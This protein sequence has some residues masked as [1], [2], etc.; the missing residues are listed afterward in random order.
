[1]AKLL[2]PQDRLLLA[3]A[4]IGDLLEELPTKRDYLNVIYG[5]YPKEYNRNNYLQAF[6]RARETG[7][8][9]KI[10]K[11]GEPYLRLTAKGKKRV[12]RDFPLLKWRERPW[13]GKWRAVIFDIEER[14][15]GRRDYLRGRLLELG[16]GMLQ[17]SVY[18]SPFDVAEDL[19]EYLEAHRLDG[20]AYVLVADRLFAGDD[21]AL[22]EKV[23]SLDKINS[24]YDKLLAFWER[25]TALKSEPRE[26]LLRKIK[27]GYLEILAADP[28]LPRELL[29]HYW[30][31]D[32]V[33]GLVLSSS[34]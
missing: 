22:A 32:K 3:L 31:G 5:F 14:E 24:E 16:F 17:Q 11:D 6:Y 29:P 2:R 13:D 9:R 18:I 19:R 15:R 23:W 27:S 34:L 12:V 33:K 4:V 1:M 25:S 30:V 20:K 26:S 10:I 8:I 7:D 21:K 28:C